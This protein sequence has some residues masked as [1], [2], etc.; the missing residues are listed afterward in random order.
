MEKKA[1]DG[2]LPRTHE[3]QNVVVPESTVEVTP[4]VER[5]KMTLKKSLWRE[6][7][8]EY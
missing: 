7:T 1:Q 6:L 4:G 2:K 8:K 5:K 3:S